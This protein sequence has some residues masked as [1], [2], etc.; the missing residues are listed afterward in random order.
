MVMAGSDSVDAWNRT[1]EGAL[2]CLGRPS[3][4]LLV[5]QTTTGGNCSNAYTTGSSHSQGGTINVYDYSVCHH[6][7]VA[8]TQLI[9]DT[10]VLCSNLTRSNVLHVADKDEHLRM[11]PIPRLFVATAAISKH[12]VHL[13]SFPA[14]VVTRAGRKE[15]VNLGQFLLGCQTP[16]FPSARRRRQVRARGNAG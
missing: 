10:D 3:V 5:L 2:G 16:V 7:K 11:L 13:V 15:G 12:I 4:G 9:L 14:T 1:C 8:D 6:Q